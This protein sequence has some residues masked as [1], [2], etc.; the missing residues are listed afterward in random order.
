MR[1]RA[2]LIGGLFAIII[3]GSIVGYFAYQTFKP[4]PDTVNLAYNQWD[5]TTN[6]VDAKFYKE[7]PDLISLQDTSPNYRIEAILTFPE[8]IIG[9]MKLRMSNDLNWNREMIMRFK[10]DAKVLFQIYRNGDGSY[11][12]LIDQIGISFYDGDANWHDYYIE[13]DFSGDTKEIS[14]KFDNR[15]I[16]ENYTVSFHENSINKIV[17]ETFDYYSDSKTIINVDESYLRNYN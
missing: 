6:T 4:E 11:W 10:S 2:I 12:F 1:N 17:W 8:I 16:L 9:E 15:I 5:H 14:V 13:W 7:D 3:I